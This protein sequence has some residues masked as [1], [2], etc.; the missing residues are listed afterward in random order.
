MNSNLQRYKRLLMLDEYQDK[1]ETLSK[2]T[3]AIAGVGGLGGL[4]SYLLVGSSVLN[5]NLA[6]GDVVDLSNIHRQILFNE[7]DV[8]SSKLDVAV[9]ELKLLDHRVKIKK[10]SLVDEKSFDDFIEG[11]S[12]VID[13]TDSFQSRQLISKLALQKNIDFIH[14]SVS[15]YKGFMSAFLYSQADFVKEHGC[16][17]C[18]S[19]ALPVSKEQGITGPSATMISSACAQLALQILTGDYRNAGKLFAFD[20]KNFNVQHFTLTRDPKCSVCG[21]LHAD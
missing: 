18:L 3:V 17:Q 13:L 4:C 19:G 20:L 14:A 1:L 9:R 8:G 6:D 10:C 2:V 12:L 11:A 5:I 15:G 16:Y 7:D 21:G